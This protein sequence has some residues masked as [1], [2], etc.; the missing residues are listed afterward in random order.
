MVRVSRDEP[1]TREL[2][3]GDSPVVGFKTREGTEK[4]KLIRGHYEFRVAVVTFSLDSMNT[5]VA[6][7]DAIWKID[8]SGEVE[9]KAIGKW[10][11]TTAAVTTLQRWKPIQSSSGIEGTDA[12]NSTLEVH[13]PLFTEI[14]NSNKKVIK[15]L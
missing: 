11:K 13:P 5:I 2:E 1:T 9:V 8:Y 4:L 15:K 7:A 6:H 12:A 14:S 3:F 10:E